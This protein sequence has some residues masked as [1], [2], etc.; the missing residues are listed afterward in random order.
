M[1]K[2]RSTGVAA[3]WVVLPAWL[4]R[5][6]HVPVVASTRV[7]PLAP[8]VRHTVGVCEAKPTGLPEPPPLALSVNGA[9]LCP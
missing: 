8:V 9:V 1:V 5:T 2:L 7:A 6:V 4:A 3:A